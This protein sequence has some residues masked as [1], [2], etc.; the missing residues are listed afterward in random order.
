M[1]VLTNLLL[2]GIISCA[3]TAQASVETYQPNVHYE[4]LAKP[5]LTKKVKDK[6]IFIKKGQTTEYRNLTEADLDNM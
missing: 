2:A 6:I 3:F 1:N 4:I 5:V